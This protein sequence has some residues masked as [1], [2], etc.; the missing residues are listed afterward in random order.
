VYEIGEEGN[1][2]YIASAY[3]DGP[4]LG[5]WLRGQA[6]PVPFLVAGRL[7]AVLAAAV[8]HAHERGILHRD[9]KP[10]NILLQRFDSSA[11]ETDALGEAMGYFPRICD[12]GLAKLLDQ[13]SQETCSGVPI[14]STSY[15]APEQ[16]TGRLREHGPATDV[17]ALGVILY[18]LLTGQPPHRG[19]TDLETLHLVSN[20]DP[21]PPR[22]ARP[23]L[24]RD[25]ETICLKCL[26]K[27]PI[28][29][30]A[31][32]LELTVDLR[33]FL[34]GKP[35]RA[36]PVSACQRAG[37]WA[38]R[39]PVHA[40]LAVV[41]ALSLASIVGVLVWSSA[42]LRQ[43]NHNL[44][45]VVARAEQH[46]RIAERSL[47]ESRIEVAR[48]E[49]RDHNAQLA[50]RSALA[51]QV[52]LIHDTLESGNVGLAAVMLEAQQ[53]VPGRPEPA[54]F[55]WR[56]LR[57]L[58]RPDVT[59]LGAP[60]Q[61]GH[62]AV[63]KLAISP[64]SRT[65][66]AG[67]SDGRVL[68][69]DLVEE[70]L[71]HTLTHRSGPG[72]E[73]YRLAFSPDGRFL[74]TG[75]VPNTIKLWD[76]AALKELA[77]LPAEINGASTHLRGVSELKFTDASDCV[78]IFAQGWHDG[79]IQV[80]FWSVPAPGGQP[81]LKAKLNQKQ[82]ASFGSEGPLKDPSWPRAS[83]AAAPWLSYA[84]NHL[85]LLD[86]G[87]T[88]A[89]KDGA[90]DAT[91]LDPFH[92]VPVAR[93]S[94]PYNVPAIQQRPFN[95][96]SP[97]EIE[98]ISRQ[99]RRV[100][101]ADDGRNRP[102]PRVF[103]VVA[104]SPDGRTVAVHLEGIHLGGLGVALID[105]ASGRTLTTNAPARWRVVDLAYTPDGRALVM[106]GFDSQIHV[107]RLRP[108]T[109]AGHKKETWSLAFSPDGTSLASAADDHTIKL[110]DVAGGD[111][112]ATL[113]GH[114]SLVTTVA[115]SPD[116]ARLASAGFD[117]TIRLWDTATRLHKG[118]LRGHCGRVRALAFSHDGTVLAS[119]GD[120]REIRLWDAA[121]HSELSPPLTGHAGS[122][123]SLAFAPDGKTLYS[124]AVDKT[125]R[126]WDWAGGRSRAVWP[127]EDQVY[128]LAAAPDGQTLAAAHPAGK[129]SLWD[130]GRAKARPSLRGHEGD[131][132]GLAFS[133]DGLT[134]AS[135]GRDQSVRLWDPAVGQELLTLKGH[136]A[137]VHAIAFSPDGALLATGSHDGAIK[138]WRAVA[139]R[140]AKRGKAVTRAALATGPDGS[141]LQR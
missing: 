109:L 122:V 85:V 59:R 24:P 131:V 43:Q 81:E 91:L 69:W 57:Q 2:F 104:L 48:A 97:S 89:I 140:S 4:T 6:A 40:A 101:G 120:D 125:I 82:L 26:E 73:V 58:F 103:D 11:S 45:E 78:A 83:E 71:R 126:L 79:T 130:V 139:D 27:R 87:V 37:K 110:W 31:S 136:L 54:D 115:Y 17:Y 105:A 61:L 137:P 8:A 36:R 135:A 22:A 64:D 121:N 119:A 56:Y 28:R 23:N 74:A 93:I 116:G 5:E 106:A 66:A 47:Q 16:A 86:D 134:L 128:A 53:P 80:W 138:L 129:V 95:G 20:Q 72:S 75:S 132:L 32:A 44:S 51:S 39:R 60:A 10:G 65:V 77:T 19:E 42:W 55:A 35:I 52:K 21:P 67:L 33:R 124:G 127:A 13:V 14:G 98:L 50:E 94:G 107:W 63:L 25:L 100:V 88:L 90:T 96:L 114:R 123:Y 49:E 34:D 141:A 30:Y 112:R 133:P 62:P 84:R 3:C 38:R 99:A 92:H 111:E 46:T 41:I 9:L 102:L 118:T 76:A 12:F 29:R 1:V 18:E 117:G 68:L 15:M 108:N 113:E 70:R 7:L